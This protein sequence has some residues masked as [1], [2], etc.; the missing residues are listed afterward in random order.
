MLRFPWIGAEKCRLILLDH[1][2]SVVYWRT[3]H[4]DVG[5][6][7]VGG[8]WRCLNFTYLNCHFSV[9]K[10]DTTFFAHASDSNSRQNTTKFMIDNEVEYVQ[11]SYKREERMLIDVVVCNTQQFSLCCSR[12]CHVATE[13]ICAWEQS[14]ATLTRGWYLVDHRC[15]CATSD[16]EI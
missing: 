7:D 8:S 16:H 15:V 4:V 5:C 13:Q 6:R 2:R 9:N 11:L 1:S 12:S 3:F 14:I 10:H